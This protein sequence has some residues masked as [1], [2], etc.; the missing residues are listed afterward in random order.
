MK[1]VKHQTST[2]QVGQGDSALPFTK[3]N[4]NGQSVSISFWKPTQEELVTISMGGY[5]ALT[6]IG[7]VMPSASL[8]VVKNL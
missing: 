2:H 4:S 7:D 3:T 1:P 6:V 5:I 8:M